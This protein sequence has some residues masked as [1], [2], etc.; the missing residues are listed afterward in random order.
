MI[1]GEVARLGKEDV[2]RLKRMG[3]RI[4]TILEIRDEHNVGENIHFIKLYRQDTRD[5]NEIEAR[6]LRS[7]K[8][9]KKAL[10]RDD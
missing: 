4:P 1:S 5:Q 3:F 2:D 10:L 8:W 6:H 9:G 7:Y